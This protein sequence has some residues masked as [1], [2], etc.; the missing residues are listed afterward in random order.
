MNKTQAKKVLREKGYSTQEIEDLTW[1]ELR[2]KALKLK[3]EG[4]KTSIVDQQLLTLKE[5]AGKIKKR[6]EKKPEKFKSAC[7]F[8]F[9]PGKKS[10]CFLVC[11]IKYPEDFTACLQEQAKHQKTPP[12]TKGEELTQWGHKVRCQSGKI[13]I[14][15]LTK[16]KI[17]I[18]ELA[19]EIKTS[20]SRIVHHINTLIKNQKVKI[21]LQEGFAW[22]EE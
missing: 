18:Q 20:A 2:S 11:K 7:G 14:A 1:V 10:E 21:N 16:G 4:K 12:R 19:E 8:L 22:Y 5:E 13:D 17:N 15:L 9:D 6:K 3:K